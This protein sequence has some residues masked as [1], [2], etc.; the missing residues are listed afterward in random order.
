VASLLRQATADGR[1]AR[2]G[3]AGR[4]PRRDERPTVAD[5]EAGVDRKLM[6]AGLYPGD[7]SLYPSRREGQQRG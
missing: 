2:D 6:A 7:P 1:E 5:V 3:R 4:R